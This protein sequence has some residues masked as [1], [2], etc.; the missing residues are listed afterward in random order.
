MTEPSVSH[1]LTRQHGAE[2]RVKSNPK[3]IPST[4]RKVIARDVDRVT[5]RKACKRHHEGDEE[6]EVSLTLHPSCTSLSESQ[7]IGQSISCTSMLSTTSDNSCEL[8]EN[9]SVTP[10]NESSFSDNLYTLIRKQSDQSHKAKIIVK[11]PPKFTGSNDEN[12]EDYIEDAKQFINQFEGVSPLQLANSLKTGLSK[13]PREVL[14]GYEIRG[15][16]Q[17]FKALRDIYTPKEKPI[18]K[19]LNFK[20]SDNETVRVFASR[21]RRYLRRAKIAPDSMI[22]SWSFL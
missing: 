3:A 6:S 13:E 10:D 2:T 7:E 9:E 8:S 5:A 19:L 4:S 16:T 17:L 20:Q 21:I 12:I 11:T 1:R 14:R 18:K 15:P 22:Y